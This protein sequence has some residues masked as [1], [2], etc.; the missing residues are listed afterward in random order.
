MDPS[1]YITLGILGYL[2]VT[3]IAV[4]GF[5]IYDGPSGND[6]PIMYL[7]AFFWPLA[8]CVAIPYWFCKSAFL[9][10]KR[11]HENRHPEAIMR[12]D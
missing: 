8:A 6:D 3:W 5:I 2:V 12:K 4:M 10:G 11:I 7:A 1:F 9:A